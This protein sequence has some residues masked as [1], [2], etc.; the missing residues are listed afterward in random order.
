MYW[1]LGVLLGCFLQLA[2]LLWQEYKRPNKAWLPLRILASLL[3][4]VCLACLAFSFPIRTEQT[5]NTSAVVLITEGYNDDSVQQVI[6]RLQPGK[7]YTN[8]KTIKAFNAVYLP[9]IGQLKQQGATVHVLGY[10]LTENERMELNNSPIVFHS[11]ALKN[12]FSSIGWNGELTSGEQ[13][14]VQGKFVNSSSA[15][16]KIVLSG[17]GVNLDS[18]MIG[19][20]QTSNFQLKAIPAHLDK[21]EYLI[22]ALSGKDTI[23]SEPLPV[24]VAASEPLRLLVLASSP[25][26]ENKF[27]KNWLSEKGYQF[28]VKTGI[29]SNRFDK[30]YVN[31]AAT[32][33]DRI[34]SGLLEKFDVIIADISALAKLPATDLETIRSYVS[35]K[36][37]GLV[38]KADSLVKSSAF[39]TSLFPFV[40][41]RDSLQHMVKLRMAGLD[42][43]SAVKIDQPVYIRNVPGTQSLIH[44]QQ[45]RIVA[46]SATLGLGKIIVTTLPSTYAWQLSGNK[47]DYSTYW[48]TL[49]T[50]AARKKAMPNVWAASSAMPSINEETQL[51]L[52]T[53]NEIIPQVQV[54][55][56]TIAMEQ[57]IHLPY[58]WTA[59]YW[60]A[61]RGWQTISNTDGTID[62]W[63]VFDTKDWTG[64]KATKKIETTSQYAN[65]HQPL[66]TQASPTVLYVEKE[67][68]KI[69]FFIVFVIC[70][71]LLWFE[72]KLH[73]H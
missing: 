48:Q 19:V 22:T 61:K 2:F 44:D 10:G 33:L 72:K 15:A 69:Y 43:S 20:N 67:F 23:V 51:D 28:A 34:T 25:D 47:S 60:P 40:E 17:L 37:L 3:A 7:V 11:S 66:S 64:V 30:E 21:A 68:P 42:F 41:T 53:S 6:K 29:S 62:W 9:E 12:N 4:V 36:G 31:L 13:L 24:K 50:K 14:L 73:N 63:Y 46:N 16:T 8:N 49:L 55:E 65:T 32:P 38:V 45:M 35:G 52:Q 27:L 1:T 54:G 57:D 26:F 18:T 71:G 39:Y 59:T 56:N 70:C 58:K 5:A